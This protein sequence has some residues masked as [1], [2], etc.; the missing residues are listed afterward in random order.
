M[1]VLVKCQDSVV[2]QPCYF[3]D[4][5][6][7]RTIRNEIRL[8][9]TGKYINNVGLCITLHDI[10]SIG[11][12]YISSGEGYAQVKVVFRIIVF[13]PFEGELLQGQ[14]IRSSEEGITVT[15]GFF[16]DIFVPSH[17]MLPNMIFRNEEGLWFWQ[18]NAYELPIEL[19][20]RVRIRVEDIHF[21]GRVSRRPSNKQQETGVGFNDPPPMMITASFKDQ[22][23]GAIKWWDIDEPDTVQDLATD[24]SGAE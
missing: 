5:D 22:G 8:K 21:F 3:R 17:M 12:G 18:Y 14:V 19:G 23:L 7:P 15:L 24:D 2:I 1:F 16:D 6:L 13:R 9:Y 20:D 11:D 10:S 4:Q